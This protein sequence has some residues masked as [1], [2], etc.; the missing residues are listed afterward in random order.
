MFHVYSLTGQKMYRSANLSILGHL[1]LFFHLHTVSLPS[2]GHKRHCI[3]CNKTLAYT[4]WQVGSPV[5]ISQETLISTA[6]E[7]AILHPVTPKFF[8]SRCLFHTCYFLYQALP[9]P[10]GCRSAS[11]AKLKPGATSFWNLFPNFI[12]WVWDSFPTALQDSLHSYC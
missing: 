6:A 9:F 11:L 2:R 7:E 10:F 12:S 1:V 3:W 5:F 4:F 8:L